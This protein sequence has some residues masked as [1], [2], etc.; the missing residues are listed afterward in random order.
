M[1]EVL[2]ERSGRTGLVV[3]SQLA[4]DKWRVMV[5]DPTYADAILDRIAH[6]SHRV[7][8]EGDSIRKT[9]GRQS[10]SGNGGATADDLDPRELHRQ[11][12]TSRKPACPCRNLFGT[13]GR[14]C[15]NSQTAT[16]ALSS[17]SLCSSSTHPQ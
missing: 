10:K 16:T 5:G 7:T 14:R 1:L 17:R 3:T 13:A 6:K 8:L 11:C 12:S 9:K 15:R 2:E 4:V